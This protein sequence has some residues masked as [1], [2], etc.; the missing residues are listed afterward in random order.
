MGRKTSYQ[1]G[2]NMLFLLWS[3]FRIVLAS[4][5]GIRLG[6]NRGANLT[7]GSCTEALTEGITAKDVHFLERRLPSRTALIYLLMHTQ[8][9]VV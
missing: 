7:R 3:P 2:S 4:V 9:L 8:S 5:T 6:G 1:L